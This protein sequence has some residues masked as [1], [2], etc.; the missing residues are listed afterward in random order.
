MRR[1]GIAEPPWKSFENN[2]LFWNT[3]YFYKIFDFGIL[4]SKYFYNDILLDICKI[5]FECILPITH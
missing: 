2:V 5:L 4:F 3:K 1:F